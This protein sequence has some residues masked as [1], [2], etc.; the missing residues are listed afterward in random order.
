MSE[1]RLLIAYA[2]PDD[3]SFGNGG[4]I[5][6]YIAEGTEVHLICA[7]DGDCGTIPE[8]MRDRYATVRELRLSELD[9]AAR[10]LGLTQVFTYGYKDSGMMSDPTINDP[11]C[12]WY[13]WNHAPDEVIA[14]VVENIRRVQPQVI[15]TFNAYG[16][17]G[18]PDHIAIHRATVA[19][20]SLAGDPDYAG[21][22]LPPYQPQKLYYSAMP[23][24]MLNWGIRLMRLQGKDVRRMG[25]NQDIDFQ[26]IVDN[27]EPAHTRIKIGSYIDAW[28]AASACH[29]SQGGG[30]MNWVPRWFRRVMMANQD[31]TRVIPAPAA[32]AVDEYDLFEGVVAE[33]VRVVN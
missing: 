11:D 18:H 2:H 14:R 31:F 22:S 3:E 4:M 13:R 20:F 16:G 1:Q 33:P 17:Y 32:P 9:C 6:K 8:A 12:L 21:S 10:T 26:A 25:Q 27:I 5:A 23:A 28:D 30:A 24:R 15:L 29:E 19:A 7:T